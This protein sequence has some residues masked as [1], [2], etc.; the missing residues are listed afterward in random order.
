MPNVSKPVAAEVV[1]EAEEEQEEEEDEEDE[2]V[3]VMGR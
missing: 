2:E 3:V 1:C